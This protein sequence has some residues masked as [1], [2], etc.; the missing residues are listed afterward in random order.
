MASKEK[1]L[2]D[3]LFLKTKDG[4]I[5]WEPTAKPDE[6][7]TSFGGAVSFTIGFPRGEELPRVTMR[8]EAGRL[9]LTITETTE[10][11]SAPDL[12]DLHEAVR[13][14]ALK[15]DESLDKVLDNLRK[16]K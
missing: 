2:V 1:Q 13:R 4:S 10:D 16:I 9:M 3:Q 7:I 15:V 11:V 5:T 8:D 12:L 14:A 6:F